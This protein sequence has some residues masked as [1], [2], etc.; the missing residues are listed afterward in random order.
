MKIRFFLMVICFLLF[1]QPISFSLTVKEEKELGKKVM[2]QVQRAYQVVDDPFIEKYITE[3]GQKLVLKSNNKLFDFHF[4]V[5]NDKTYNAFAV[6]GG[7]IFIHTGLISVMENEAELAGILSHEIAHVNCRHIAHK[8]E[9]SKKISAGVLAGLAAGIA[10]G[11]SGG[12]PDAVMGL[13]ASS[14]AA[15]ESAMLSFSRNDEREADN[16][17]LV[18]M[19][20]AGFNPR[21]LLKILG[22]IRSKEFLTE[23]EAPVYLRTHPGTRERLEHITAFINKNKNGFPPLK[24]SGA[25]N[26]FNKVKIKTMVFYQDNNFAIST[27]DDLEKN[28]AKK[29]LAYY[30]K[31]LFFMK[32]G[33]Y[34]KS[35]DFFS[36]ALTFN[37]LDPE[38]L[39]DYGKALFL[40]GDYKGALLKF[41][42]IKNH[43]V[44]FPEI[45]KMIGR[46]Y[47]R[48]K[49]YKKAKD[50][51]LELTYKKPDLQSPWYYLGI[52]YEK[53]GF[54]GLAHLNL[55]KF[56]KMQNNI[57]VAEF[58]YEKAIELLDGEKK[59]EAVKSFKKFK[60]ENRE[61]E[62]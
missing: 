34:D 42:A 59:E 26:S 10:L 18:Y 35:A 43:G 32:E 23:T 62:K 56:Y 14:Q 15:G 33:R 2:E 52:A 1:S 44:S 28:P 6:P 31:A 16:R 53:T 41:N 30:G 47:L 8:I 58:H 37:A 36:K 13:I 19:T 25:F 5:I 20:K 50:I 4:M 55:A 60:K 9:D 24:E 57:K 3:L 61:I 48:L 54:K 38:I 21:G 46:S 29:P 51:F 40:K 45:D 39:F 49:K 27:L 12:D 7:Y 17:G 22:K 11:M